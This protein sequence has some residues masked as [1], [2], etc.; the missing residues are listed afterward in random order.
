MF[1]RAHLILIL[2]FAALM[3]TKLYAVAVNDNMGGSSPK[4]NAS[5]T[6]NANEGEVC[7]ATPITY[8][9]KIYEMGLCTASPYG[10]AKTANLFDTASCVVTYTDAAPVEVDIAATIGGA[11]QLNGTSTPPPNGSYTHAYMLMSKDFKVSGSIT[12][13]GGATYYS[14]GSGNAPTTV[15][16][17]VEQT[18]SLV[19]FD[20]TSQCV[21]GYLG[22]TV[23]GGTLDGFITDVNKERGVSGDKSG[24]GGSVVCTTHVGYVTGTMNLITP[25]DVTPNTY[26]VTFNFLVTDA[27]VLWGDDG[28]ST[29]DQPDQ[30]NNGPFMG[31]FTVLSSD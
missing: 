9:V 13:G 31:Y 19:N 28:N 15:A 16:G 7:R 17:A 22:A 10:A 29:K 8:K 24:A 25:I 14:K 3:P 2:I 23:P 11:V 6:L 26:S 20:P 30:F 12:N 1:R 18:D 5:A 27:G 4:C 21:S